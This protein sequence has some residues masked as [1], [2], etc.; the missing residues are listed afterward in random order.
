VTNT[1][2]TPAPL[3]LVAPSKCSCLDFVSTSIMPSSGRSSG[4]SLLYGHGCAARKSTITYPF[5]AF[6]GMNLMSNGAKSIAHLANLPD[7]RDL[8]NIYLNGSAFEITM[9]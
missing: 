3:F 4:C 6:W 1:I 7:S 2:L 5:T 9:I 8:D